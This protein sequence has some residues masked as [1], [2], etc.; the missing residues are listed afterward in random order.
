MA[1]SNRALRLAYNRWNVL[2]FDNKL[3]QDIQLLWEPVGAGIAEFD[4]R[5]TPWV[6]RLDPALKFSRSMWGMALLHEMVHAEL[7]PN[8][9]HG[10]KFQAAM[11]RLAQAGAFKKLW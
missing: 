10:K 2:Y 4:M 1:V 8:G 7:H 11:M 5:K 9:T 6:I 3:P